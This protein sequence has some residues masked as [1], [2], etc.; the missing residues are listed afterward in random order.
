MRILLT[1]ATG[2]LGSS[3]VGRF[4]AEGH[5]V[6]ALRRKNSSMH[7]LEG[8][9]DQIT[10]HTVNELSFD[11]DAMFD[12]VEVVVH[13]ATSYGRN[14]ESVD[15][16]FKT[17]AAFPQKLLE[18]AV[19]AGVQAFINTGTSLPRD[20]NAYS[21]SKAQF[22]DFGRSCAESSGMTFVNILPDHMYGPGDDSRKFVDHVIE[23]CLNDQKKL[24]LT[25]GEQ[26]RDF[27]FIDD[28]VEAYNTVL[29]HLGKSLMGYVE[30]PLGSGEVVRIRDLV[31]RIR[32]MTGSS[33][34]LKFGDVPYR[35]N[36]I[37]FSQANTEALQALGWKCTTSLAEGLEKTIKSKTI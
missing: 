7:R 24:S 28:V 22:A 27:I 35:D 9:Q 34:A 25:A 37:M 30:L 20:F 3:L 33:T 2:F 29:Q 5:D 6:V 15:E 4:L 8:L 26:E 18:N 14:D 31:E 12:G 13:T 16:V 19:A 32:E 10:W 23:V 17:N 36:E 1:G 11:G 21:Q